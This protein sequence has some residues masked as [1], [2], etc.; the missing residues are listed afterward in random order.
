MEFS[1]F[2][3]NCLGTLSL[4]LKLPKW[5]KPQDFC[6]Y[7]M[8][9]TEKTIYLQSDKR[10]IEIDSETGEAWMTNGKGG[11]PNSWLLVF[12]RARGQAETFVINS[13]DLQALKM[14]IFTTAGAKVGNSVIIT[15]NSGAFSII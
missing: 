4:D 14:Q 10:W 5:R 2:H 1:N 15:D 7:P 3:R 6:V 12:Q 11:H 8:Q 13:V 9:E